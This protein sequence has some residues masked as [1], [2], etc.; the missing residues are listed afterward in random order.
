MFSFHNIQSLIIL[1]TF[2]QI[3]TI[4]SLCLKI[5]GSYITSLYHC[6]LHFLFLPF[7]KI[8]SR[9]LLP[10]QI[11]IFVLWIN[12]WY[13]NICSLDFS[14]CNHLIHNRKLLL[15]KRVK[16]LYT[17]FTPSIWNSPI[18]IWYQNMYIKQG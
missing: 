15:I 9:I 17:V 13:P 6:K 3:F 14:K 8:S 5:I 4:Q 10:V 2:Y 1:W 16:C 11:D 12:Y 7:G 18:F